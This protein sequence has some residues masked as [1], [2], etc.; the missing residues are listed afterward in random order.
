MLTAEKGKQR[1]F[2]ETQQVEEETAGQKMHY[3]MHTEGLVW[4][5]LFSDTWSQ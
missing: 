4:F 5:V 2:L 1:M 3:E